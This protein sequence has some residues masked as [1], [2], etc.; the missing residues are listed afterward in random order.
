LQT[1]VQSIFAQKEMAAIKKLFFVPIGLPG[2]G[3]TT[4]AKH[5]ESTSMK[6]FTQH[7]GGISKQQ[8][9]F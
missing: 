5:L 3:K 1:F 2:M 4:L 9:P 7:A 8:M 6:C